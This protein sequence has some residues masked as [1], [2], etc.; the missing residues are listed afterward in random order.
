MKERQRETESETAGVGAGGAKEGGASE[1]GR[2][3]KAVSHCLKVRVHSRLALV[4]SQRIVCFACCLFAKCKVA[5]IAATVQECI[6]KPSA[7]ALSRHVQSKT[8]LACANKTVL[9]CAITACTFCE[10]ALLIEPTAG[11]AIYGENAS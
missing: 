7:S 5:Q 11:K 8:V 1:G 9:T 3:G 6:C 2:E 10:N 4:I